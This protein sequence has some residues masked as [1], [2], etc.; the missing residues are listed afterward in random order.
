MLVG[1]SAEVERLGGALAAARAGHPVVVVVD[2]APGTGKTTL[3]STLLRDGS[4]LAATA[5]GDEDES[6]L[7]YG[8]VDQLV[9]AL[10]PDL[11]DRAAG[12]AD[13]DPWRAG[14]AMVAVVEDLDLERPLVVVV[15]DA[16]WADAPSLQALTFGA[17]RLRSVPVL[18]C[19]TCRTDDLGR[20]PPGLLRLAADVGARITLGP[21]DAAAVAELGQR[22]YGRPLPD[23]AVERLRT[24]TGGNPLHT[25]AL[26]DDLPF[27]T[28]AGHGPLPAPRSLAELVTSVLAECPPDARALARALAVLGPR[29]PLARAAAVAGLE[30]GPGPGA[31]PRPSAVLAG[32]GPGAPLSQVARIAGLDRPAGAGAALEAAE[33]LAAQGL[34]TLTSTTAGWELDFAHGVVRASV[35]GAVAPSVRVLLH[36][37]AA[38]VTHGDEALRHRLAAAQGPDA[39]LV[40]AATARA[41]H[42]AGTGSGAAGGPAAARRRPRRRRRRASARAWSSR[43]PACCSAPARR[44][45][46]WAPRSRGSATRSGAA[47]CS[48]GW[49]SSPAARPR[50][51]PGSTARGTS[52]PPSPA[53]APTWCRRW[54]TPRRCWPWTR[55]GGTT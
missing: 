17:R 7:D 41:R 26:L 42:H 38:G 24:H 27:D 50:R 25:V 33:A 5:S 1:R 10:P 14:A 22:A 3:A 54:P 11:R 2:G 36:R 16:Q 43:P 52:W 47:P 40:A 32:L 44:W 55:P 18:V 49:R 31:A 37:R 19:V 20:L 51:G 6:V 23:L 9:R 45:G 34:V 35:A 15:D 12:V 4:V 28:V 39:D 53:R 30:A 21:L 8:V 29:A 48:D 46:S 13:R